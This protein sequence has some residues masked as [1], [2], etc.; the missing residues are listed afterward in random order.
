MRYS[1]LASVVIGLLLLQPGAGMAQ[2]RTQPRI[3]TVQVGF[4]S[5][6]LI[7]EF[8]SGFWAPV[9]IG[10]M[11]GPAG[12]PRGEIRVESVDSDDVPNRY[13]VPLPQLGP[14]EQE[15][16]LAFTKPGSTTSEVTVRA[17]I[18]DR[19]GATKGSQVSAIQGLDQQF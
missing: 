15:T 10:V 6:A 4:G 8:K 19:P 5:T 3:E 2:S 12:T 11:A 14:N 1:A 16:L 13:T 7:T 18:D 17:R 9:Y